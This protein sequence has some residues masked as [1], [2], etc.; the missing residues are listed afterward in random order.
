MKEQARLD[1]INKS[2]REEA[3]REYDA[4]TAEA[5]AA[6]QK[7]RAEMK[8]RV[9]GFAAAVG[10]A[11]YCPPRPEGPIALKRGGIKVRCM[12]WR[13]IGLAHIARHV[14]GCRLTQET[15]AQ[16]ALDD[17][18]SNRP[19]IYCSPRHRVPFTQETRVQSALDDVASIIRQARRGGG[20]GR[21]HAGGVRAGRGRQQGGRGR[22]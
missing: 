14:I 6:H 18:A 7:F 8:R 4:H 16:R 2:I 10:P 12:T 19:R 5:A 21:A 3:A 11:G 20:G 22:C 15:R 9:A 13:A 17:V 1:A